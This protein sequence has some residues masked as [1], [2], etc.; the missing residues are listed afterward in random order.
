MNAQDT[1][2]EILHF[3]FERFFAPR[4]RLPVAFCGLLNSILEFFV[5]RFVF[6]SQQTDERL[7]CL[8]VGFVSIGRSN[9][10]AQDTQGKVPPRD[11]IL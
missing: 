6:V 10:A 3:L 5:L 1:C 11:L 9:R 4:P 7:K 8:L 2:R